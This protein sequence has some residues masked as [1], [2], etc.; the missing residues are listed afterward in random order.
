MK[1]NKG[2]VLLY[3]KDDYINRQTSTHQDLIRFVFLENTIL[4]YKSPQDDLK[5]S[6]WFT[7]R[8]IF[9]QTPSGIVRPMKILA[10]TYEF[11][12]AT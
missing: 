1:L 2:K 6:L 12:L 4:I 9:T 3:K 7:D 8:L 10:Y 11:C 5:A